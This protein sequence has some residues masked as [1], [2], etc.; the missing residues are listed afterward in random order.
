MS[1]LQHTA[2]SANDKPF[3]TVF[4]GC[5]LINEADGNKPAAALQFNPAAPPVSIAGAALSRADQLHKALTLWSCVSAGE[6]DALEVAQHLEPI[7]D[8]VRML[9]DE[10]LTRL[11]P[12][13][14]AT[15]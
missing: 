9:L 7:A 13:K 4:E 8:E 5:Y 15:P 10:L 11:N 2:S 3:R 6:A 1:D 14:G 12:A